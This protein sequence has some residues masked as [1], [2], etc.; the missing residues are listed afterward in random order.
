MKVSD[1]RHVLHIQN[2]TTMQN[3]RGAVI[4]GWTTSPQ[5]RG[6][7]RTFSGDERNTDEQII[8]NRKDEPAPPAVERKTVLADLDAGKISFEDAMKLLEGGN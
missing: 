2:P 1:L 5:L 6:K 7:V 3:E 4:P 8:V